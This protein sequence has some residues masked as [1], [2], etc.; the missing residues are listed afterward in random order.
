LAY[1]NPMVKKKKKSKKKVP[2]LA[3]MTV[4]Y[5]KRGFKRPKGRA[6]AYMHGFNDAKKFAYQRCKCPNI[7]F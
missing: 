5:K 6:Q 4:L 7:I 1:N 2:T 3:S